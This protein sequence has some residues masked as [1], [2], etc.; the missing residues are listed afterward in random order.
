M[1]SPYSHGIDIRHQEV[2]HVCQVLAV[3]LLETLGVPRHSTS[4]RLSQNLP[5]EFSQ[6]LLT[7]IDLLRKISVKQNL[8]P[9]ES[10]T[11]ISLTFMQLSDVP[12]T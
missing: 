1:L 10:N 9:F 12:T 7:A 4:H 11:D 3:L 5:I 2:R 8:E 6:I